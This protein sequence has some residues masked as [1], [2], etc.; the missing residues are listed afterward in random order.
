RRLSRSHP[1]DPIIR[2]ALDNAARRHVRLVMHAL[3]ALGH[4]HTLNLVRT[5][6]LS[7]DE[8][9]RANAIESLASLPQRRFVIPILPLIEERDTVDADSAA[10]HADLALIDEALSSR[11]PWIRAAAAVARHR[12]TG[13]VPQSLLRDRSPIVAETVRELARRPADNPPYPQ[14]PLMSR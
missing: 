5:M 3:D 14:E 11:D 6:I 4:H 2:A 7:R 1:T 12:E 9:G 13:Q 10:G 8:R